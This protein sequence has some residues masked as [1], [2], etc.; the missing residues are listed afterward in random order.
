[1]H[2]CVQAVFVQAPNLLTCYDWDHLLSIDMKNA[3]L[4]SPTS[5]IHTWLHFLEPTIKQCL[6]DANGKLHKHQTDIRDNFE[7][8]LYQDSG[9]RDISLYYDPNTLDSRSIIVISNDSSTSLSKN[10]TA[11]SDSSFNSEDMLEG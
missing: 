2:G 5:A 8:I 6:H 9:E 10:L 4:N 1:M 3:L 11:S 7:E